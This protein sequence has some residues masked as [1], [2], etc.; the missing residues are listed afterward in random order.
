MI[1]T[2]STLPPIPAAPS[3]H[4]TTKTSSPI[5]T[6]VIKRDDKLELVG[7]GSTTPAAATLDHDEDDDDEGEETDAKADA[8]AVVAS[9][10]TT[11]A[12]DNGAGDDALARVRDR[13]CSCACVTR[14]WCCRNALKGDATIQ[15]NIASSLCVRVIWAFVRRGGISR[16]AHDARQRRYR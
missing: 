6:V 12:S 13:A 5:S 7:D 8:S 15:V 10:A 4:N 16:S 9:T 14:V 3:Q 2:F 11:N 1:A